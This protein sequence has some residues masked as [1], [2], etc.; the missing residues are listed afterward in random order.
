MRLD[1]GFGLGRKCMMKFTIDVKSCISPFVP[2]CCYLSIFLGGIPQVCFWWWP[3]RQTYR[4]SRRSCLSHGPMCY[5][6]MLSLRL[7]LRRI[8]KQSPLFPLSPRRSICN[9]PAFDF[10]RFFSNVL[11]AT[12]FNKSM[13]GYHS[14]CRHGVFYCFCPLAVNQSSVYG[15]SLNR[16]LVLPVFNRSFAFSC[17]SLQALRKP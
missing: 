15:S 5:Q 7:A 8:V 10:N 12:S 1:H 2:Q 13:P 16:S 6:I 4:D 14:T 3:L 9:A 11:V 17:T